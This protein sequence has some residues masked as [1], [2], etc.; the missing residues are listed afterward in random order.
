MVLGDSLG[1]RV[2]AVARALAFHQCGPGSFPGRCHTWIE[3]VAG[4]RLAPGVFLRVLRLSSF[5]KT[6]INIFKF[7]FDQDRGPVWKPANADGTS[8]LNIVIYSFISWGANGPVWGV[9][10]R[11]CLDSNRSF[12]NFFRTLNTQFHETIF[13]NMFF[14]IRNWTGFKIRYYGCR[15]NKTRYKINRIVF[16]TS[17]FDVHLPF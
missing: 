2:G 17:W 12:A 6:N 9:L 10:K 5:T 3:F 8:S 4:S 15:W 1:I 16:E 7:Q 11:S 14:T 13:N